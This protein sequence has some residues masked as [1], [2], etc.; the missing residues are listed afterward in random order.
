[1]LVNSVMPL[2]YSLITQGEAGQHRRL[3]NINFIKGFINPMSPY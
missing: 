3:P 1:M 2:T